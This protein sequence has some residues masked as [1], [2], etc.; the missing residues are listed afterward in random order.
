M[1]P[2]WFASFVLWRTRE[3]RVQHRGQ[4]RVSSSLHHGHGQVGRAAE[5]VARPLRVPPFDLL[6]LGHDP[7]RRD[8]R[9]GEDRV[10]RCFPA[11]VTQFRFDQDV[12]GVGFA[13]WTGE[14]RSLLG[15]G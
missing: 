13:D 1:Y 5:E 15:T 14:M 6:A 10:G 8:D 2:G 12:A 9:L 7:P 11:G 4:A 3:R